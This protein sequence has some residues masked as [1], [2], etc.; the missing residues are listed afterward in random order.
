MFYKSWLF[1]AFLGLLISACSFTNSGSTADLVVVNGQV[2]TVDS[3]FSKAEA[4]AIQDGK[5][6]AVGDNDEVQKFIGNET[7]VID[8]EGKT[9][10]PGLIE[11]HTHAT[12][13]VNRE[14]SA[15]RAYEQLRSIQEIQEWLEVQVEQT[16]EG[17]WIQLP[18]AEVTRIKEGR[19]PTSEE[20]DE[21]TPNNPAVF[22]WQYAD[23]QIQVLNKAAMEA[24]GITKDTPVPEGGRIQ[25]G[26]DGEPTGRVEDSPEL[27]ERFLES[28]S[29]TDEEYHDALARL[30]N[31]YNEVGITSIFERGSDEEGYHSFR[32]LK[33]E[34][35]LTVRATVTMRF[36]GLDG[37]IEGAE[38]AFQG[39]SLEYGEGDDWVRV[40]PLKFRIDGG[41]LYG[42]AF[43]REP[44]GEASFDL[45]GIDDPTYRGSSVFTPEQVE[46]ILHVGQ[47]LGWQMS[48]HV[49][50]NAG[51]DL[52]LDA[53]EATDNLVNDD[54]H[55]FT[56]I[57]AYFANQG[58]AERVERLGVGIDT[59]PPWYHMDGDGL[60]GALGEDRLRQFIGIGEWHDAGAKV[61]INSDHMMGFGP[62]SS[63]NPYNP[64]LTMYTVIT[65]R[66][67]SGEV[68]GSDQKVSRE[69]ALRM[70]TIDAAWFSFDEERKG[71]IEVGKLGDFAILSDDFFNCE[72]EEIKDIQSLMTVVG[73]EVVHETDGN[74]GQAK[75]HN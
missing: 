29:Y 63:L 56:L 42:T 62:N 11:S 14:L 10:I 47:S 45:Y 6:I 59:Q 19:I 23:R 5:F 12:G 71:S 40:G 17:G 27:T 73:G 55:R 57:H 28:Q 44:Y 74:S 2:A 34:G 35:R 69:D 67:S 43:M 53:I 58:T 66:T 8:A 51:V 30:L 48:A 1:F 16:P 22:N 65:R 54:D 49:T 26:S 52:V 25:L 4:F 36:L 61:S 21:V 72:E 50:G 13:V 60:L 24:A 9:I 46:N 3:E 38:E 37:T 68:I 20:L 41:V 31:R 18:R 15:G 32:K 75:S 64:F 39:L 7:R 33:E 70:M